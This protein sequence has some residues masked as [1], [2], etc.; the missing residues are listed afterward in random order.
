MIINLSCLNKAKM[1]H[2]FLLL[3]NKNN[4][5]DSKLSDC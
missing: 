1:Q 2:F 4:Q 5:K 3:N